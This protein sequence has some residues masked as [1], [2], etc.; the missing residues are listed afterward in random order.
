MTA[1][2]NGWRGW[3]LGFLTVVS[4]AVGGWYGSTVWS[5]QSAHAERITRAET[6]VDALH[7]T[8][9]DMK[10]TLDR[11]DRRMERLWERAR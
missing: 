7:E 4:M 8:L 9:V 1:H 3:L 2:G 10:K 5:T 11:V 6:R